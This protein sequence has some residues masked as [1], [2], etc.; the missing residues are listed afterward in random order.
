MDATYIKNRVEQL[1]ITIADELHH[2]TLLKYI[3]DPIL[4]DQHLFYLLLPYLNG[5][6]WDDDLYTSAIT[7]AM[8][9]ASLSEHEKIDETHATSKEQQLT[10][11]SGDYYSGRYYQLLAKTGNIFLIREISKSIVNRCENQIKVYEKNKLSVR[12]WIDYILTIETEL[13]TKFYSFYEFEKYN[14]IMSKSLVLRRL[15]DELKNY[16]NNR[17]TTFIKMIHMSMDA[18]DTFEKVIGQ[19][20]DKLSDQVNEYLQS[21]PLLQDDIKLYIKNQLAFVPK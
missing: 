16:R 15:L 1:K 4:N 2:S 5:E 19:E 3:D 21:S 9:H 18:T 20:V 10:V 14:T 11:L 13:I 7:V 8:V 6:N 12:E 17:M